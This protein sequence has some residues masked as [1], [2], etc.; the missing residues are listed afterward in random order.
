MPRRCVSADEWVIDKDSEEEYRYASDDEPEDAS[1]DTSF[2]A[3][4]SLAPSERGMIANFFG[5]QTS[6]MA[7]AIDE[8]I[9]SILFKWHTV[10]PCINGRKTI[11]QRDECCVTVNL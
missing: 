3:A 1:H 7:A 8:T 5:V 9:V 4:G 2:W 11:A 10:L 6:T